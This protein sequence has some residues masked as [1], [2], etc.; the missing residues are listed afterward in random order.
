MRNRLL[1]CFGVFALSCLSAGEPRKA[2]ESPPSQFVIGRDTF[3]DF[4]PPFHYFDV[5]SVEP[6]QNGTRISR[7]LVTPP[8]DPCTQ[9]AGVEWK[10]A[11][12]SKSVGE[13]LAGT[14][15]CMISEHEL[16]KEQKRCKH[17]LVFSGADVTMRVRCGADERQIRMDILDRDI[18]DPGRAKTPERT[19]WTMTLLS[20]LDQALGRGPMERPIFTISDTPST[21]LPNSE[22][23]NELSAGLLDSLFPQT[24]PGVSDLY[25]QALHPL[26]SPWVELV[27]SDPTAPT[28][29]DLP[30]YPPL[31]RVAHIT[32]RVQFTAQ[33]DPG[34]HLSDLKIISGHPLLIKSVQESTQSWVYPTAASGS[35]IV[36]VLEFKMNCVAQAKP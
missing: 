4:G 16:R 33:I 21:P 2:L 24:T 5:I 26:P 25:R 32:G 28:S 17:C 6:T 29:H 19:S 34:G 3:F 14:N 15:P 30:K 13:L 27:S 1:S 11:L 18:Y 7:I 35:Q 9:P 10:T 31:A 23:L 12:I 36:A 20:R 8:G 22:I